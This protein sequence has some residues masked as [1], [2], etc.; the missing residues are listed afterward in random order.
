[1]NSID[2]NAACNLGVAEL[3]HDLVRDSS[4]QRAGIVG[5]GQRLEG[6]HGDTHEAMFVRGAAPDYP[7]CRSCQNQD[8]NSS[9]R[10]KCAKPEAAIMARAG[11]DLRIIVAHAR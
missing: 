11:L 1:L 10:A 8:G 7:E 6:L 3:V 9:G 2:H 4:R 5:T